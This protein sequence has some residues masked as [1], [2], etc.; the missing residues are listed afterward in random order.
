MYF[1]IHITRFALNYTP[2]V[3]IIQRTEEK[4][5]QEFQ[6]L[7]DSWLTP[8]LATHSVLTSL[9]YFI[10]FQYLPSRQRLSTLRQLLLSWDTS[11][12]VLLSLLHL[13]NL[14]IPE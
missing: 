10:Q 6:R 4:F 11:D 7:R 2:L 8:H 1:L 12:Y 14:W 3:W 9:L 13:K 5:N